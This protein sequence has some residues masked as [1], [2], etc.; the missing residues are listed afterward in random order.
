MIRFCGLELVF[1]YSL[2]TVFGISVFFCYFRFLWFRFFFKERLLNLDKFDAETFDLEI[3]IAYSHRP[4]PSRN[5]QANIKIHKFDSEISHPPKIV[6]PFCSTV[7]Y[8]STELF[9]Y[10][11][12]SHVFPS[13]SFRNPHLR[14]IFKNSMT[15]KTWLARVVISMLG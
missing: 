12:Y 14:N 13:C 5:F 10:L 15:T 9:I 8:V 3:Y 1:I 6:F 11:Y 2:V 4:N 7:V